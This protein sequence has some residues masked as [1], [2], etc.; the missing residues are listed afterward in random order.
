M[1]FCS[2]LVNTPT[3]L[4]E[5][6]TAYWISRKL[7]REGLQQRTTCGKPAGI[8]AVVL[9]EFATSRYHH[10]RDNKSTAETRHEHGQSSTQ[11]ESRARRI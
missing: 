2:E 3:I 1:C 8:S 4:S 10:T 11:H 7:R 5:V 6:N 9:A